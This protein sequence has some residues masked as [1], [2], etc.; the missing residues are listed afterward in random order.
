MYDDK[1]TRQLEDNIYSQ[2]CV[3]LFMDEVNDI[4]LQTG[5]KANIILVAYGRRNPYFKISFDGKNMDFVT[6]YIDVKYDTSKGYY[7]GT[8]SQKGLKDM[9]NELVSQIDSY[10]NELYRVSKDSVEDYNLVKEDISECEELL[11]AYK[12]AFK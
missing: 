5:I 7:G 3:Q 8:D 4:A 2:K 1:M 6:V 10:L 9:E 11:N 12:Q